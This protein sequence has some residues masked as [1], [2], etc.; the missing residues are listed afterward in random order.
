M[1]PGRR[2][3]RD[4]ALALLGKGACI[5]HGWRVYTD[6]VELGRLRNPGG[7]AQV[8]VTPNAWGMGSPHIAD[9]E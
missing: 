4:L 3:G 1:A 6:R 8:C 7:L 9:S 5:Q 2:R